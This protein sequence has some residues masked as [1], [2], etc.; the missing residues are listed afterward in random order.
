MDLDDHI[1]QDLEPAPSAAD[2]A[3][4]DGIA[5]AAERAK[6]KPIRLAGLINGLLVDGTIN[7]P[8][9]RAALRPFMKLPK[10]EAR[11]IK[12]ARMAEAMVSAH[13]ARECV[14]FDDLYA[15]GFT[16][17]DIRELK[18]EARRA[19]RLTEMAA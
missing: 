6:S 1:G 14:T 5:R 2:Q 18:H 13:A 9:V 12:R 10:P 11:T 19:A 7:R 16:D 15:A 3:F 8:G 17:A 4:A